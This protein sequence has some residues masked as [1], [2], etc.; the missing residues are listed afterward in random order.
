MFKEVLVLPFREWKE[1]F[2]KVVFNLEYGVVVLHDDTVLFRSMDKEVVNDLKEN[3]SAK[4]LSIYQIN[5]DWIQE[6]Y[7]S[8]VNEFDNY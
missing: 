6:E 5:F 1:N 8:L 2:V 7:L 4:L 3:Q